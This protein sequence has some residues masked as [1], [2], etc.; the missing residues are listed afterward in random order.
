MPKCQQV[1]RKNRNV[2]IGDMRD[3]IILQSRTITPPSAG[4]SDMTEAFVTTK[5]VWALVETRQGVEI[6]DNSNLV[7]IATHYFYIRYSVGVT[8]ET[9]IQFKSKYYDILDIQN[10]EERD[11]FMLLRCN[12]RGSTSRASNYA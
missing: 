2:C 5:T 10:L 11:E 7:G 4:G 8:A 12:E 9:W 1:R 6:F 3:K